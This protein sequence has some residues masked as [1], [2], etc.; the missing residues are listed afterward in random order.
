MDRGRD[1]FC[2]IASMI[3]STGYI[4]PVSYL[5]ADLRI[6]RQSLQFI[7]KLL[8]HESRPQRNQ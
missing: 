7:F 1:L 5:A 6:Q 3:T 2:E 4:S 8:L